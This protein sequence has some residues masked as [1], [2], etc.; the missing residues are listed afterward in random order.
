[1]ET[2]V[3]DKLVELPFDFVELNDKDFGTITI[4]GNFVMLFQAYKPY[5]TPENY[6]SGSLLFKDMNGTNFETVAFAGQENRK[7]LVTGVALLGDKL[8]AQVNCRIR[9]KQ[10]I[11]QAPTWIIE[12][13]GGKR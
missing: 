7:K 4:D 2:N 12:K 6:A 10:V 3:E 5:L 1:M 8:I 13:Y 11:F 9:Y